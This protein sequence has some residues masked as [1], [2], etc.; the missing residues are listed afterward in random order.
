[1]SRLDKR[2]S[3]L[4]AETTPTHRELNDTERAIRL[5]AMLQPGHPR[6]DTAQALLARVCSVVDEG[7]AEGC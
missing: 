4:E 1:M 5:H 7:L 6:N 3:Q 2:L